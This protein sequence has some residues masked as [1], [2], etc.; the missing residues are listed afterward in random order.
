MEC[1]VGADNEGKGIQGEPPGVVIPPGDVVFER[2]SVDG[3]EEEQSARAFI[4][5]HNGHGE[6]EEGLEQIQPKNTLKN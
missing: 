6:R 3:G 2:S 1:C 4:A 5:W